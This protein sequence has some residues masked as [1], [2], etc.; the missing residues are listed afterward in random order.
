MV[1]T[2]AGDGYQGTTIRRYQI[3]LDRGTQKCNRNND[4]NKVNMIKIIRNINNINNNI[5]NTYNSKNIICNRNIN[6]DKISII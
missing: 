1:L 3:I 6:Y 2:S 4:S 5:N